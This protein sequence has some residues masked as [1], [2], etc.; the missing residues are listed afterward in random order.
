MTRSDRSM[1]VEEDR[2]DGRM[3]LM[4]SPLTHARSRRSGTLVV[5]AAAL[6]ASGAL[7]V[8]APQSNRKGAGGKWIASRTPAGRPDLQGVWTNYDPTPFERLSAEEQPRRGPAVST[9]DWL[10]QEGPKSPRRESM[11]VDPPN[12]R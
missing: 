7:L 3:P 8:G 6:L 2:G 11:V 10:V 4:T 12:G 9:A 1:T 5:A